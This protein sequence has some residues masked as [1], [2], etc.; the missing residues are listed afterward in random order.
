[1]VLFDLCSG[2]VNNSFA[3]LATVKI[4]GLY[5]AR[6][7]TIYQYVLKSGLPREFPD[8]L[9]MLDELSSFEFS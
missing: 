2:V 8:H 4:T 6:A 7:Q 5:I 9:A 1:M 3:P